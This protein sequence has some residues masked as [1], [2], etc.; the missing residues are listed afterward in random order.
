M[1]DN[2]KATSTF[3]KNIKRKTYSLII[4]YKN[5]KLLN[6]HKPNKIILTKIYFINFKKLN[7][8]KKIITLSFLSLMLVVLTFSSCTKPVIEANVYVGNHTEDRLTQGKWHTIRVCASDYY[9]FRKPNTVTDTETGLTGTWELT[10]NNTK[11]T[12]KL[13]NG[14]IRTWTILSITW[15]LLLLRIN[16][17]E[18]KMYNNVCK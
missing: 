5:G 4:F 12:Q 16:G 13:S 17:V 10:E 18:V 14:G 9:T 2:N 1:L 3:V 8:M 7:I 15:D 11:L 6:Y